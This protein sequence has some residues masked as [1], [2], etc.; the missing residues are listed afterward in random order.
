MWL[1]Q[2]SPDELRELVARDE[3]FWLDLTDPSQ[4]EVAA[5]VEAAG[6]DLQAAERALRFEEPPALRRFHD[7]VGLVFYGAQPVRGNVPSELVE[8][9]VFVGGDWVIT[10]REQAVGALDALRA[11][12]QAGEPPPEQ[13]V[14]A[15]VLQA[16]ADSFDDLLD[17]LE[18]EVDGLQEAAA[19]VGKDAHELRGRI[20]NLRGRLRRARRL[21]YRQRDYIGRA[22]EELSTLPGLEP[23]QHQEL[24][25]VAGKMVRVADR[26]EDALT[27]LAAALELLNSTVSNRMNEVMERLTIVATIFLPLTVVTGFFGMNFEWMVSHIDTFAGFMV[28]GVGVFVV[29]GV[30]IAV[31]LRRQLMAGYED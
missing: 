10:V 26:F 31:W 1:T 17:G 30:G 5:L 14:V 6:L 8:V 7:H 27:R 23:G 4:A 3:F 2:A 28:F 16:L 11:E 18:D 25:D 13:V 20:L 24:R 15:R 19:A 9:H 29:S 22:V 21:V 12:L